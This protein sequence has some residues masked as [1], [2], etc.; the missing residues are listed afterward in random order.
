MPDQQYNATVYYH[1][2]DSELNNLANWHNWV[3]VTVF[4][5]WWPQNSFN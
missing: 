1:Q 3:H 5:Y 4:C 2:S